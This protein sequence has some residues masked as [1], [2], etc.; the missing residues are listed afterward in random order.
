KTS[1]WTGASFLR[2]H[3]KVSGIDIGEATVGRVL[4]DLD[5][6]GYTRKAGKL[7]RAVTKKGLVRLHALQLELERETSGRKVTSFFTFRNP[8]DVVD[9]LE[10]R[11]AIERETAQLAATKASAAQIK[12]MREAVAAYHHSPSEGATDSRHDMSLHNMIAIASKNG[13]LATL[14][15]MIR[16]D[17]E[18]AGIVRKAREHA[19]AQCALEHDAILA[20]IER[21]DAVAAQVAMEAHIDGMIKAVRSNAGALRYVIRPPGREGSVKAGKAERGRAHRE[22]SAVL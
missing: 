10:V 9:V 21:R 19:S 22:P 15:D 2:Q 11:R 20:A 6:L 4:S 3:L 16:K 18:V 13:L 8:E 7:G 1:R 14:L 17:R 5:V 12:A